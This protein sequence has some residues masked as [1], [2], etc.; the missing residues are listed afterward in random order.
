MTRVFFAATATALVLTAATSSFA[1]PKLVAYP[2][3]YR[4]WTHV[5]SMLIKENH[6]LFDAFGGIHHIYANDKALN[7]YRTGKFPDGAA[8]V[9]DLLDVKQSGDGAVVEGDRKV[10]GVMERDSAAF[11]ETGGWG[12]EGFAGGSSEKRVV[13]DNA[14]A[15]CFA[16]H[17]AQ[18][19]DDFVF[20][21]FR[22]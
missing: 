4:H 14:A 13:G 16:C 8:I 10:V 3:G 22:K 7:G 12:F 18:A 5:K 20:S 21:A 9:F 15:A 11:A 6:P 19:G 1:D 2:D 17:E